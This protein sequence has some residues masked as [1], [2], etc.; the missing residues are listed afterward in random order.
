VCVCVCVCGCALWW[1]GCFL[2][3]RLAFAESRGPSVRERMT[4]LLWGVCAYI[5]IY[6]YIYIR[7]PI[8]WRCGR[9]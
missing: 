8:R 1:V 4:C 6:I 7:Y 5:D 3:Y 9:V 2:L